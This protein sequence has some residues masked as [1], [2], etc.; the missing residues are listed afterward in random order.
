MTR[1]DNFMEKM[2]KK[3]QTN[4]YYKTSNGRKESESNPKVVRGINK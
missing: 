1:Y 3:T 2:K 4:F